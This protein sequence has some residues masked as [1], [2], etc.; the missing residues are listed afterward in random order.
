MMVSALFLER[1]RTDAVD[2]PEMA[3]IY[4]VDVYESEIL[5]DGFAVLLAAD[6]SVTII[7]CRT[8]EER[9]GTA[10]GPG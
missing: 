3:K 7:D 2:S 8:E 4:G 5:P 10:R 9:L 6:G 1:L